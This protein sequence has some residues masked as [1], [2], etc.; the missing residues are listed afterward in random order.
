[1]LYEYVFQLFRFIVLEMYL[2][3]SNIIWGKFHDNV[4]SNLADWGIGKFVAFFS[5]VLE[6][7]LL[8]QFCV[9]K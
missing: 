3:A 6:K 5:K 9:V 8:S 7:V 1:M 4:T 2:L